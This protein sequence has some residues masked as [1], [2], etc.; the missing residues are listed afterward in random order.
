M[1]I[2]QHLFEQAGSDRAAQLAVTAWM[3]IGAE[4]P[5]EVHVEA[6]KNITVAIRIAMQ[7]QE[8]AAIRRLLPQAQLN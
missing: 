3:G 4:G 6:V 2:D 8:A 5:L 1:N 7:E